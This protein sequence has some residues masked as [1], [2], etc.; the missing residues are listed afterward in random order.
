MLS[1]L[2]SPLF[3]PTSETL[4]VSRSGAGSPACE[5]QNERQHEH[6]RVS[7]S[8][9][10]CA[11]VS[12]IRKIETQESVLQ[13]LVQQSQ[14]QMQ[15]V[16]HSPVMR[17]ARR[18]MAARQERSPHLFELRVPGPKAPCNFWRSSHRLATNRR[19]ER[20]GIR[21]AVLGADDQRTGTRT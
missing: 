1:A 3:L 18:H 2:C 17:P 9:H 6:E 11:V 8:A 19:C 7:E 13:V 12:D 16:G 14:D 5:N 21:H 20:H 4:A 10:C 15:L